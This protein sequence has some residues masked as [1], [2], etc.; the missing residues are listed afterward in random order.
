MYVGLQFANRIE[1]DQIAG[2]CR[3]RPANNG[4]S[5]MRVIQAQTAKTCV[6]QIIRLASISYMVLLLKLTPY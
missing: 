3:H 5:Q 1:G 6:Y 4:I 2:Q